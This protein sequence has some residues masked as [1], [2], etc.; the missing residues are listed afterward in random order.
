MSLRSQ[1]KIDLDKVKHGV[2]VEF[3]DAPNSDG[4]V[5]GFKLRRMSAKQNKEYQLGLRT[6]GKRFTDAN[7]VIDVTKETEV[8]QAMID[9]FA[10]T[11]L[12]DWRNFELTEDGKKTPYTA[13]DALAFCNDPAWSELVDKLRGEADTATI[14]REEQQEIH[15]KN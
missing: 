13:E 7:G 11:I 1:Y 4:T 3:S 6:I 10:K 14:Y 5:P 9:L 15:A 8:E 12:I 2:W